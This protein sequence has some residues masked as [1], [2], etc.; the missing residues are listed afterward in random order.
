MLSLSYREKWTAAAA[1]AAGLLVALAAGAAT[2]TGMLVPFLAALVGMGVV[3]MIFVRPGVG[4]AL[5]LGLA[6]LEG[7]LVVGGLSIMKLTTVL[8]VGMIVLRELLMREGLQLDQLARIMA[9]FVA[10]AFTSILWS[11]DKPGSLDAWVSFTLQSLLYLVVLNMVRSRSDLTLALW[12]HIVGG[13]VLAVM[14]GNSMVTRNF[15]RRDEF[16]GLGINLAARLV[17]LSLLLAVMQYQ[18]QTRRLLK[19]LLI[20]A[21]VP[22]GIAVVLSLSRGAWFS[23]LICL[24]VLFGLSLPSRRINIGR[25]LIWAIAGMLGFYVLSTFLFTDHGIEK[26]IGRFQAAFTT[27]NAAGHRFDIW[28]V[29]WLMFVDSPVWG[30]GFDAFST[31]FR[32]YLEISGLSDVFYAWKPKEPHNAFVRV[33][34][35][36]GLIGLTIFLTLL[37]T[38]TRKIWQAWR[39]QGVSRFAV[40][41]SIVLFVFLL[42]ASMVDSSIDRK[43]LWY[44]LCLIT[45]ILRYL[46]GEQRLA[47]GASGPAPMLPGRKDAV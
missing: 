24:G 10:W 19:G 14:L 47:A 4:A 22:M 3:A 5:I 43:Y 11:P 1:A 15:L 21:A 32:T 20:V 6:P 44:G 28:R 13:L 30:L 18:Y 35:D 42:N 27:E 8:C 34:V 46:G 36:L 31:Q 16:A 7:A 29:G 12:G 2:A 26:L 38:A 41:W 39:D 9:V 23:T 17:S 37:G 25:L 40:V 33:I 45:L